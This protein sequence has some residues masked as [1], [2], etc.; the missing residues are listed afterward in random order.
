MSSHQ[1]WWQQAAAAL[2]NV[3]RTEDAKTNYLPGRF[4]LHLVR[5][6]GKTMGIV[7]LSLNSSQKLPHEESSLLDD[8]PNRKL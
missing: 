1:S 3:I 8:F 4:S 7:C 5:G 6:H 2:V